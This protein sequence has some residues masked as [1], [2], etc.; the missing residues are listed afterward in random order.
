VADW[1]IDL[2][3]A[4]DA[5][6]ARIAAAINLPRKR[7]FGVIKTAPEY[8]GVSEG[9]SFEVWERRDRAVHAVGAVRAVPGGSRVDVAFRMSPL[10]RGALVVFFPL[11]VVVA[12]GLATL[13]GIVSALDVLV[14]AGG[15]ATMVA[16]FIDARRRQRRALRAFLEAVLGQTPVS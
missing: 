15:L 2:R 11:Y 7:L 4:P 16:F 9:A 13:D 3:V 5:A 8:V 14:A 12:G 1:T 6:I 10:S